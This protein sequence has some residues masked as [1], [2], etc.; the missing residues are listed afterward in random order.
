M[1]IFKKSTKQQIEDSIMCTVY[2][3]IRE[4]IELTKGQYNAEKFADFFGV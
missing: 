2:S 4:C 3:I 1:P